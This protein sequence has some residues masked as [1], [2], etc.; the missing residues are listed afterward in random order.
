MN[1]LLVIALSIAA[2]ITC[3]ALLGHHSFSVDSA[4]SVC[5]VQY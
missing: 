1:I 4:P 3:I 2:V 5:H